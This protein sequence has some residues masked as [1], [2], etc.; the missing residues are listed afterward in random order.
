MNTREKLPKE[1]HAITH[2]FALAET[3]NPSKRTRVYIHA[4]M[5][6]DGRLGEVFLVASKE[7]S[8]VSALF[9][10]I[11]LLISI[12][13][14]HGVPLQQITR[15]L[16]FG[17]FEPSVVVDGAPDIPQAASLL[18]YIGR[19]LDLRFPEG[20]AAGEV[21]ELVSGERYDRTVIEPVSVPDATERCVICHEQYPDARNDLGE[22]IHA[23]TCGAPK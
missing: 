19:Y 12:A 13:L 14:Q 22:P 6:P 2:Q 4:G 9:D 21:A 17:R 16:R 1:R 5:H 23:E 15:K 8:F 7:G 3:D 18:D 10:T 20:R 11:A